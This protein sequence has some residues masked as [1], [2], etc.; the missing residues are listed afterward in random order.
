MALVLPG[1]PGAGEA[2]PYYSRYIDRIPDEDVVAVLEAQIGQTVA[3]LERISEERSRH[4]YEAGKWSLR[5]MMSHVND[6]E[7]VFAFRAFWF[8][9]GFESPLPDY[10]QDVCARA[11]QADEVPW[12]RHIEEFRAVRKATVAFF[13]NLPAEAWP[14]HGIASGNRFTVRALA[15]ILAGHVSH[16]MAVLRDRYS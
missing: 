8:A 16:H 4:R 5:E 13:R 6:T 12:A 14:R 3:I 10:D 11:A 7:R 9:R 2:A 15:Y 1:R